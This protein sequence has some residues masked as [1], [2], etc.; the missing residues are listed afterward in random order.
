M[1]ETSNNKMRELRVEKVT[2]NI[3]VGNSGERLDH[4]K[5]LLTKL[6]GGKKP[7]ETLA[8]KRNP[9]FHLRPGLPIGA[10]VTLR[11]KDALE[12][13]DKAL[14]A[15]RRNVKA[16]SFDNEGNFSFGVPEYIDFPGAKYDPKMGVFGFDVCV[17]L[18]RKGRR[19][20]RRRLRQSKIGGGHRIGKEEAIEYATK[21]LNAKIE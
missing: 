10:K 11:G 17:T 18:S 7:I 20:E 6:T 9:V 1:A 14:T 15:R 3:G 13:L 4:A 16:G 5:E 21:N 8:K 12:F 2:V 19:V